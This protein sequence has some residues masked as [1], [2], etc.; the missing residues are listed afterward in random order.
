MD[1]YSIVLANK[2]EKVAR[3][4]KKRVQAKALRMFLDKYSL[5]D[6]K[7]TV[8]TD[9]RFNPYEGTNLLLIDELANSGAV[10]T[11]DQIMDV[12]CGSGLFMIY[13]FD[14]GFKKISG[15]E[16]DKE[17]YDLCLNNIKKYFEKSEKIGNIEVLYENAIDQEVSD[18]ITCFYLFNTFYDQSTYDKWMDLVEKSLS[19]NQ[20]EI[21]I[22]VLYPTVAS[23]VALRSREWLIESDR[24]ICKAQKCYQCMNFIVYRSKCVESSVDIH[25]K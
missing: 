20:R 19:R 11:S 22:I 15:I 13:M 6:A 4:I 5:K 16:H 7:P 17:L 10:S 21:K 23:M 1:S 9:M 8:K 12:G 2:L 14:K 24:I 18:D 25:N 3:K